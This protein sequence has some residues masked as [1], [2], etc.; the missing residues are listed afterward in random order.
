REQIR[1]EQSSPARQLADPPLPSLMRS[2]AAAAV[3]LP[4]AGGT[5]WH[6]SSRLPAAESPPAVELFVMYSPALTCAWWRI[7]PCAGQRVGPVLAAEL[8]KM[9]IPAGRAAALGAIVLED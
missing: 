5:A 7:S 9:M 8:A 1:S 4:A 6:L 2:C 3:L